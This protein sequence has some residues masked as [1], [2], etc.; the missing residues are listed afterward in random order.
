MKTTITIIVSLVIGGMIT[1]LSLG[2]WQLYILRASAKAGQQAFD[3]LSNMQCFG[4]VVNN[5]NN[6]IK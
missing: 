6:A 1:L 4:Q 3:C 2:I 5:Y